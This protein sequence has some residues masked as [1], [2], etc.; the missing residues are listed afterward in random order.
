MAGGEFHVSAPVG[1][2]RQS[3]VTLEKKAVKQKMD[4]TAKS[5]HKLHYECTQARV[6]SKKERA[7]EN[8]ECVSY[9]KN[10]YDVAS[11]LGTR[12]SGESDKVSV[13]IF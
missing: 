1:A 4:V 3:G 13:L 11:K 10:R 6:D 12:A 5:H 9:R 7:A 8:D 2:V